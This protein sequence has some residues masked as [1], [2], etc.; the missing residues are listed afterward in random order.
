[1]IELVRSH[2][3]VILIALALAPLVVVA[4]SPWRPTLSVA[5]VG[6]SALLMACALVGER[7]R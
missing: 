1:M 3:R 5:L 4:V 7:P 2:W 6:C